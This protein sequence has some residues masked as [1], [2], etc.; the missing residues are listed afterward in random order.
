MIKISPS[1]LSADFSNIREDIKKVEQAGV[2]LLHIDVMDGCF[3][4]NIT[5]GQA[6]VKD[7]RKITEIPFDVHL[8]IDKPERYIEDFVDAG[9]DI[10]TIHYE[11][12]LHVHRVLQM[13]KSHGVKAGL[14]LN[15]ATPIESVK[16]LLD[17]VDMVLI[18]TVNP[19]FGG[20]QFIGAM[21]DKIKVLRHMIDESGYEID[22]QVD[23]G[24]KEANIKEVYE[25]GA[26]VFVAGSAVFK[27]DDIPAT[28]SNFRK[29]TDC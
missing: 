18:M 28:I 23:G 22:I 1:I 8:M 27:S 21:K 15:P 7:F 13:I 12:T 2:D 24:I 29:L 9:A 4:P 17:M 3:V 25:C 20:Q 26:N 14:A 11:S 10:I 19:G 5:F 16:H 6:V